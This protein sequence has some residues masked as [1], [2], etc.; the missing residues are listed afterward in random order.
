MAADKDQT[1]SGAAE[2]E[3]GKL[4]DNASDEEKV[5]W[6]EKYLAAKL[7]ARRG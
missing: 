5:A 6:Y 2:K 1:P 7:K 4:K 3:A